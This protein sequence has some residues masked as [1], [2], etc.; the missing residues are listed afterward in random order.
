MNGPF[1][2]NF[3]G[4]DPVLFATK[5][6]WSVQENVT[7]VW[8]NHTL[9]AGAFWEHVDNKQ[10]GSDNNNGYIGSH[11]GAGTAPGTPSRTSSSA[12]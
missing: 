9:K 12:T 3:G 8:G 6:Q 10:P 2:A 7:K 4:F 5:W 1:Y 11:L